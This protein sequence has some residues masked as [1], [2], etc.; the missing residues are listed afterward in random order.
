LNLRELGIKP[1]PGK[2]K[3]TLAAYLAS[4]AK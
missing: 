3:P 1:A 4:K 2:P